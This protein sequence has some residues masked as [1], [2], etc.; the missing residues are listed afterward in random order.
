MRRRRGRGT[1][2]SRRGRV[3]GGLDEEVDKEMANLCMV[4]DEIEARFK[5]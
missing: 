5:L 3:L 1:R 4:H 2:R